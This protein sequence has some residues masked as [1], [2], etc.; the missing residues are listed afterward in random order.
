MAERSKAYGTYERDTLLTYARR[1]RAYLITV[2][3]PLK[4]GAAP[5]VTVQA[6]HCN[7]TRRFADLDGAFLYLLSLTQVNKGKEPGP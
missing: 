6:S 4:K 7:R 1:Q 5:F 2:H 3:S